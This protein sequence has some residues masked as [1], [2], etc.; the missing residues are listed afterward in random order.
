MHLPS[1]PQLLDYLSPLLKMVKGLKVLVLQTYTTVCRSLSMPLS[2]FTGLLC[3]Y[4]AICIDS[5]L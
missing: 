1:L 2:C 4:H 5:V 3:C